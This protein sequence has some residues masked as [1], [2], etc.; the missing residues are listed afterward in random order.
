MLECLYIM[1]ICVLVI[2]QFH[3]V[4]EI[5]T[6][7]SG[8]MTKG[9]IKKPMNIKPFSCSLCMTFWLSLFYIIFT[10]Q[11][12]ILTVLYI[13]LLSYLT[14]IANQIFTL[15]K[16]LITKFLDWLGNKINI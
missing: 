12:S 13:L 2:D 15:I 1:L 11:F 4:D 16:M 5:T 9:Q 10:N 6:I 14:T 7:I 8:W 3:F